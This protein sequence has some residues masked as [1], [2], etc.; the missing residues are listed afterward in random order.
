[1]K[2]VDGTKNTSHK[3][4]HKQQ[5]ET[6]MKT[7]IKITDERPQSGKFTAMWVYGNTLWSD[8]FFIEKGTVKTFSIEQDMW[9]EDD[10]LPPWQGVMKKCKYFTLLK[11]EDNIIIEL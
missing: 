5:K 3:P 4:F 1:M 7:E 11:E 9:I 6:I 2:K 8:D 10:T